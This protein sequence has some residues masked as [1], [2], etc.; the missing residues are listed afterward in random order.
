MK[1]LITLIIISL[2]SVSFS[3]CGSSSEVNPTTTIP[4]TT[5]EN[6]T[7]VQTT[8]EENITI[9]IPYAC[10]DNVSDDD[11]IVTGTDMKNGILSKELNNNGGLIIT[12]DKD[13][14]EDLIDYAK[15]EFENEIDNV[16]SLNEPI[17]KI[18]YNDNLDDIKIYFQHEY[19]EPS[20][21]SSV[22]GNPV[23]NNSSM[24]ISISYGNI[25]K[26]SIY[27]QSLIKKTDTELLTCN[28]STIDSDNNN[29]VSENVYPEK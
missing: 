20:E 2:L 17:E 11:C 4:E 19:F 21:I 1:K 24:S 16:V 27:Y 28:Y 26:D 14:Y 10:F 3:A 15:S 5:I 29:V 7:E 23:A 8:V 13:K 9:N 25:F 18:E 22:D 12:V 6:T